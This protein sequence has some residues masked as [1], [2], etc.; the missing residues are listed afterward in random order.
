MP[1]LHVALSLWLIATYDDKAQL[2][3]LTP[4]RELGSTPHQP[5]KKDTIMRPVCTGRRL[6]LQV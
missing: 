1:G 4:P 5:R 3:C 6:E 2:D